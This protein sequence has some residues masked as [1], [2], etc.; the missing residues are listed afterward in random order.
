MSGRF[1]EKSFNQGATERQLWIGWLAI[2][3][4]GYLAVLPVRY[5]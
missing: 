2:R 4:S 1:V 5:G 3:K